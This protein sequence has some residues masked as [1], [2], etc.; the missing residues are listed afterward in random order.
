MFKVVSPLV[1][2]RHFA[3]AQGQAKDMFDRSHSTDQTGAAH[4]DVPPWAHIFFDILR[5][6]K[7]C[8]LF[9]PKLLS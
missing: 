8:R 5:H 4:E 7:M 6:S 2:L 9:Q 3:V 1:L